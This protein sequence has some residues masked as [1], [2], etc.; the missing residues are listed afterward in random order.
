M[1]RSGETLEQLETRLITARMELAV[2]REA[3]RQGWPKP[4]A[5]W[6]MVDRRAIR[7]G[8]EP[9]TFTGIVD[10]VGAVASRYPTLVFGD[11]APKE[12]GRSSPSELSPERRAE[13]Q[14]LRSGGY[15]RL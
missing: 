4:E 7:P 13:Q 10:A 5:A 15:Y 1:S 3:A 12:G 2:E 14:L 8:P 6:R 9:D 11:D